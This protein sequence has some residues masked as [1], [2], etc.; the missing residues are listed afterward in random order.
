MKYVLR[1]RAAARRDIAESHAWY[2]ERSPAAA[3]RFST[4][5]AAVFTAV[6]ENPL[7]FAKVY[8][9][10][11][12]ALLRHYPYAVYF[13]VAAHRVSVLRVLHQARDPREW[14]SS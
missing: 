4:E 6:G 3:E 14:Q 5:L 11:R 1:I 12:R 13:I 2:A 10:I 9:E 7:M 8:G